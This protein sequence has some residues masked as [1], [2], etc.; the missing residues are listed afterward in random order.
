MKVSI[1]T[2]SYNQAAYLEQT[3]QS[4][5][6]QDYQD[7]E[8]IVVDAGSTD[9]S[10]EII[11]KYR[12]RIAHIIFKPD[13]GPADGLNKG[14]ALASGDIYGFLNSDDIL[15]PGALR[16]VT[17]YFNRHP[18]V[19]IVSG[20][21]KF[22]NSEG[23]FLRRCYSEPMNLR[24]IAYGSCVIMQPSTFFRKEMFS[25][26]GGFNIENRSNWDSEL[27]IDMA[28][29]GAKSSLVNRF[30]SGARLH[31]QSITGSHKLDSLHK[32]YRKK[33]FRKIMGRDEKFND[34]FMFF[35]CRFIKHASN[36]RALK[37]RII[38]GSI[39]GRYK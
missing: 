23:G 22:I 8:Y 32:S 18:G 35:L 37:E 30:W 29:K 15:L 6:E 36:P 21:C 31:P 39:Y 28:M 16:E 2:I 34:K 12:D 17:D 33:M 13:Q 38:Y 25:K 7:V 14:F 11:E 3:I 20:H 26:I 24:M 10:R 27:L 4:V 5:L 19:D 1:V 9:G